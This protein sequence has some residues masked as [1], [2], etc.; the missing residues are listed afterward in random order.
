ML[1][2]FVSAHALRLVCE[3]L[4]PI[5]PHARRAVYLRRIIDP[6][7]EE[8]LMCA[9]NTPVQPNPR[10][11]WGTAQLIDE[12]RG[13]ATTARSV[14]VADTAEAAADRLH[15]LYYGPATEQ[16]RFDN[17]ALDAA[18]VE[19]GRLSNDRREIAELCALSPSALLVHWRQF[20]LTHKRLSAPDWTTGEAGMLREL[21]RF[22]LETP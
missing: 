18:T 1:V 20:C 17:V 19:V 4:L 13:V 11:A 7:S 10:Q 6:T 8:N 22:V 14:D 2:R 15:E 3:H 5:G 12:L 16:A 9:A 21:I